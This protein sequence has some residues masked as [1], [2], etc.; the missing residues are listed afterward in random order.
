MGITECDWAE[1]LQQQWGCFTCRVY[2]PFPPECPLQ[3]TS[4]VSLESSHY[5]CVHSGQLLSK[6]VRTGSSS[7]AGGLTALPRIWKSFRVFLEGSQVSAAAVQAAH[8]FQAQGSVPT[9]LTSQAG[10]VSSPSV[11]LRRRSALVTG[12]G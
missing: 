4:R 6:L 1:M 3:R 8:G 10:D 5:T 11:E 2:G 7:S 9:P 12:W